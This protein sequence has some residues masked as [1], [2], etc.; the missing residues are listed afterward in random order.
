MIIK[1]TV[2]NFKSFDKP[3]EL[4]MLSSSKIQSNPDHKVKIKR[5]SLLKYGVI[6]GANASGKTN[7]VD[8][9]GFFKACI[10]EGIP[11]FAVNWFC[12]NRKSNM[13]SDSR[14][15]IQFTLGTKFYA[16]GFSAILS[17]RIITGE[18]LYELLEIGNA[19]CLFERGGGQRP[20]LGN[21]V[22][23]T[24]V[25]KR[26][27]D[28]YAEDF[29][30]NRSSLFLSEM[31]R[32]KQFNAQSGLAFFNSIYNWFSNHLVV[33][34]PGTPLMHFEHY[35][36]DA[37]LHIINQIIRTL[38]TGISEVTTEETT[39]DELERA[40]PKPV[41]DDIILTVKK[42]L[43][44]S[45]GE[46]IQLTMRS[47]TSFFN[48][49]FDG[50]NEPI[51][52]TIKT[53]HGSSFY[54]FHF[55]DESDGTRRIFDLIDILLNQRDDT[56]YVIDELER[57]LHPKLTEHYLRLLMQIHSGKNKQLIFT[58]HESSIMDLSLFRRDEIWFVERNAQ[59]SSYLYPLDRFKVRYDK[60]ISKDYLEGRYGAIPVFK[61]F[62]F[63]EE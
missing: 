57:S 49:S 1:I 48:L 31:N 19:R 8:F 35:Y 36:D 32:G 26:R 5:T 30:A 29:E 38:D 59:N 9:F 61:D 55:S 41:F 10:R 50:K 16:Y 14:F 42:Q 21:S 15:E 11:L 52:K 62:Q 53:S 23:L 44:E 37:S 13:T 2:E 34:L 28:I 18:W 3:V 51:I 4:T 39:L 12:K 60:K 27:F 46:K 63:G 17:E 33:I 58:T 45:P 40:L 25:E 56:V 54:D 7:L 43:Q 6:Y 47:D 24:A 22:K 20:L